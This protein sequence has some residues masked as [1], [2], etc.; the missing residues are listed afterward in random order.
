MTLV[1][2]ARV[3]ERSAVTGTGTITLP[4]VAQ[5]GGFQT[6]NT[7]FAAAASAS[8]GCNV[9]YSIVDSVAPAW[10]QGIGTYIATSNTL[11]RSTI[12]ESS[13]SGGIVTFVGNTCDVTVDYPSPVVISGNSANYG[14]PPV[15]GSGGVLD[16]SVI[17]W[18]SPGAI[19]SVTSQT[20]IFT[21]ITGTYLNL[22]NVAAI[23]PGSLTLYV[24]DLTGG[25]QRYVW[26][27]LGAAPASATYYQIATLVAS[28]SV[29]YDHLQL[30]GVINTGWSGSSNC[31]IK[32][33]MGNRN[34][35]SIPWYELRGYT[36]SQTGIGITCFNQSSSAVN[37]YIVVSS[38]AFADARFTGYGLTETF[39]TS[40]SGST[41][42]PSGTM[43]FDSRSATPNLTVDQSGNVIN[44]GG[45]T[46][47]GGLFT[48]NST[49][50]L[51]LYNS[52]HEIYT[53]AGGPLFTV[54]PAGSSY[55]NS[56]N[57]A[58]IVINS[59]NPSQLFQLAG[60]SNVAASAVLGWWIDNL[61]KD[62]KSVV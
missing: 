62:R 34:G 47:G 46:S 19:G 45:I 42:V 6:F 41:T 43:L 9:C 21:G 57:T 3:W 53:G 12:L 1:Y 36:A 60:Y 16:N 56:Q 5:I 22:T 51:A 8:S 17:N 2:K 58:A 54:Y 13:A 30:D 37:V 35:L 10:E 40:P 14:Q 38:G 18:G 23:G 29:T 52:G 15:L 32:I 27:V 28:S 61:G 11:S 26:S 50:S 25:G 48:V 4:G 20:G 49:G 31:Y 33:V 7:A 59:D 55:G 24:P 44:Q 39:I